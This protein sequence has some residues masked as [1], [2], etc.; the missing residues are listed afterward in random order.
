MIFV[1]I[2]AILAPSRR[3]ITALEW[4]GIE[5]IDN[6]GGGEG[7]RFCKCQRYKKRQQ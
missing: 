7:V 6:N 1:R 2:L 5:F 3:L 4:A